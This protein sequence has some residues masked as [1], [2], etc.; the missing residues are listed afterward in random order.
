MYIYMLLFCPNS[1]SAR[2]RSSRATKPRTPWPVSNL[3]LVHFIH[4]STLVYIYT[5]MCESKLEDENY[6]LCLSSSCL[7]TSRF[8]CL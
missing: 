8:D 6:K 2:R 4:G 3:R 1:V 7:S 5:F